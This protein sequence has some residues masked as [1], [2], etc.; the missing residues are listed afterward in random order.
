MHGPCTGRRS[1]KGKEKGSPRSSG[2]GFETKNLRRMIQ[3]SEAFPDGQIVATLSRQLNWS[4]FVCLIPLET[5]GT[6]DGS[7]GARGAIF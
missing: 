4:Q 2:W 1:W 7:G 3:F 5:F 6:G